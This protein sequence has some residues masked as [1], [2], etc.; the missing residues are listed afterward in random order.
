[1]GFHKRGI[2]PK[3]LFGFSNGVVGTPDLLELNSALEMRC[4]THVQCPEFIAQRVSHRRNNVDVALMNV[5]LLLG[6]AD[7]PQ[8]PV[9]YGQAIVSS[10]IGGK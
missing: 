8:L 3:S 10:A 5:R 9:S 2:K 7:S 1:M 4:C 6:F